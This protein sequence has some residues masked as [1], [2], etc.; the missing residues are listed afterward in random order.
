ME[1]QKAEMGEFP[2][3][4]K[5][6]WDL[7]DAMIN[8][9]DR[10]GWK[11]GIYPTDQFLKDSLEKG[12]LFVLKNDGR[13]YGCVILNSESNEDYNGVPWRIECGNEE[14]LI[15]HALAVSLDHQGMGLGKRI[16][17]EILRLARMEKKKAVRLDILGTNVAAEKLYTGC[18]FQ[19]V[20]AKTMYYE[21]TGW[22]EY[23]MY[24]RAC[25]ET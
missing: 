17:E 21:D 8:Q 22:T 12:E 13:L 2:V 24:E 18:G 3:I 20:Q 14:V 7:I 15:P 11:K 10:I 19:F 25:E 5:F 9:N 23:K 16:V 1:F 6:Y 4:K